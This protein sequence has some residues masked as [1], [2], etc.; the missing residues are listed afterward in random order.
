MLH[1]N[2]QRVRKPWL[3]QLMVQAWVFSFD[4]DGFI[5]PGLGVCATFPQNAE[6]VGVDRFLRTRAASVHVLCYSRISSRM[7]L[8]SLLK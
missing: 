4:I 3:D 2:R 6:V 7:L 1:K 5:Y 8:D